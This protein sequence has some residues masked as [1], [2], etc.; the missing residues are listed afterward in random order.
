MAFYLIFILF[1]LE[2]IKAFFII[3]MEII[4]VDDC[5]KSIKLESNTI[6][7]YRTRSDC[8][9]DENNNNINEYFFEKIPYEIGQ[10]LNIEVYDVSG[11]CFLTANVKVNYYKIYTNEK[12]F[13]KCKNYEGYPS[14]YK[15]GDMKFS[16]YID[17][18]THL[19]DENRFLSFHFY[20]QIDSILD[21]PNIPNF[22]EFHF[23]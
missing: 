2:K 22:S 20:L 14:N 15:T 16:C 9:Y 1:P 5:I 4:N 18:S 17:E 8:Y 6:L 21:L 19:V 13:W 12:Q 7:Y 11:S 10:K 3:S 23:F